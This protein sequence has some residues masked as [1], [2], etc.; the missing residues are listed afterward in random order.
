M[1]LSYEYEIQLRKRG[2]IH[3]RN[4]PT[5]TASELVLKQICLISKYIN[6]TVKITFE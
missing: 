1:T 3:T 5:I 4:T 2:H 6:E